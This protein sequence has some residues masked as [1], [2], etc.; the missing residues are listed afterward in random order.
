[1]T[2]ITVISM[3]GG[4]GKTTVTSN[5]GAMLAKLGQHV[6]LI[7]LDP[8]NALRLH[9]GIPVHESDGIARHAQDGMPWDDLH[10][11]TPDGLRVL[12]FGNV[13]EE[14]CLDLE[15]HLVDHPEWLRDNLAR[16]HLERD[17]VIL[18]DTPPGPSIYLQQ[19]LSVADMV[20]VVLLTDAGSYA[21]LPATE[22]LLRHYATFRHGFMGSYY[23]LNQ[24]D[25]SKTLSRDVMEVVK[26][27]LGPRC[28]PFPIHRD[29]AVSES[30]AYQK[31]V[32]EY[33]RYAQASQDFEQFANWLV[34]RMTGNAG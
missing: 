14:E 28:M 1:M 13:S 11:R 34:Q 27:D 24:V 17:A 5:L 12:P 31:T 21:V 29:E 9:C 6:L 22:T 30:L 4:V 3:K 2:V 20:L 32:L 7:D 33:D 19:A 15:R 26:H 18:V 23:V 8:Q 10:F 16:L 25:A